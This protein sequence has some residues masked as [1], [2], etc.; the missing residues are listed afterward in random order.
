MKSI[1]THPMSATLGVALLAGPLG[2]SSTIEASP[3]NM[4]YMDDGEHRPPEQRHHSHH[5]HHAGPQD[6]QR[7]PGL[8]QPPY[9]DQGGPDLPPPP[10]DAW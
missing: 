8:P 9:D 2:F 7:G 4:V 10:P 5:R 3:H 1:T 6:G